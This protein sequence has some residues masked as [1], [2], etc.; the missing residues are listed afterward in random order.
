MRCCPCGSSVEPARCC[1][2]Y[3]AGYI[4][5]GSPSIL[6]RARY[7]AYSRHDVD[8]LLR[9][10]DPDRQALVDRP[11]TLEWARRSHWLGFELRTQ[12][13]HDEFDAGWV[14]FVAWY[15]LDGH[16][17]RHHE[18]AEFKRCDAQWFYC[19]GH[20]PD[21]SALLGSEQGRTRGRD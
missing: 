5:A 19:G 14:E 10:Y 21:A 3:L 6:A 9:T 2:P 8:F 7:T 13:V 4:E 16:S 18:I 12:S 17:F 1:D 20:Y 15:Q 11:T